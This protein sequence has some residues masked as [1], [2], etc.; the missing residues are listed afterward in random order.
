MHFCA[1]GWASLG[2]LF[3]RFLKAGE[4]LYIHV[5]ALKQY[6]KYRGMPCKL[7]FPFASLRKLLGL[8]RDWEVSSLC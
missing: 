1:A 2:F 7:F 6:E 3:Y 4:L 5:R 8:R